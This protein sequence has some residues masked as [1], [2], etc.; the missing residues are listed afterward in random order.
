[1]TESSDWR[2]TRS[3]R[4]LTLS[5]TKLTSAMDTNVS[6]P[7]PMKE[8]SFKSRLLPLRNG[9]RGCAAHSK[10]PSWKMEVRAHHY[11]ETT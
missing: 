9:V 10:P 6:T 11:L 8:P 1:M 2:R 3:T 4:I 7:I 5:T